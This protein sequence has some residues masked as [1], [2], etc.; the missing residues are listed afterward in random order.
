MPTITISLPG[1]ILKTGRPSVD[2]LGFVLFRS[3]HLHPAT[4]SP[5][6][7][8]YGGPSTDSADGLASLIKMKTFWVIKY[9]NIYS[10]NKWC[11]QKRCRFMRRFTSNSPICDAIKTHWGA[12]ENRRFLQRFYSALMD[13]YHIVNHTSISPSHFHFPRAL[14]FL[15]H[16]SKYPLQASHCRPRQTQIHPGHHNYPSLHP[17]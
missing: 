14:R 7:P 3:P 5:G 12:V 10:T 15:K 17:Y 13:L 2:D 11:V 4:C 16:S 6:W 1:T 8:G 9:L